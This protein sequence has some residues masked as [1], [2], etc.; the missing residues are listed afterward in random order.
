MSR[1]K[2]LWA[3]LSLIVISSAYRAQAASH[4]EAEPMNNL[5]H[6]TVFQVFEFRRYTIKPGKREQFAR[7]FESYFPEAFQQLGAL[8]VGEFFERDPDG[9]TW[10]RAFRSIED[11]AIIN[12]AFYYGPV[13]KEHKA[14]LNELMLDSDNVLLLAPLHPQDGIAVLPAVDPVT[15]ASGAQGIVVA[16]IFSVVPGRMA[17][18]AEQA[19]SAFAQYRHAGACEAA[20]L[21]TLDVPNNFPQLPVR[22]DGP[23]LVWI[24]VIKDEASF[25][26]K[27]SSLMT[28]SGH[29]LA[30]TGLVRGEPETTTMT[31]APR[32][33]LRWVASPHTS[34]GGE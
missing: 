1:T 13:W 18:L 15:E 27:L 32:S 28:E 26:S 25:K 8:A 5:P 33:R 6:S 17:A 22:T 11:R 12:G 3:T 19:N 2:A 20:V 10:I 34:G 31:P 30:G 14:T 24:G 4:P 29:A 21:A 16:Q 9:F 7:Y 23:Y